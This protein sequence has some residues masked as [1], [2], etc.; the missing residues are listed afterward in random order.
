MAKLTVD[1]PVQVETIT[2]SNGKTAK[3][4]TGYNGI[5]FTSAVTITSPALAYR[6]QSWSGTLYWGKTSGAKTWKFAT[7][8]N[9]SVT[10][11]SHEQIECTGNRTIYITAEAGTAASYKVKVVL[12]DGISQVGFGVN[13]AS[14]SKLA[15]T[16]FTVDVG[17]GGYVGGYVPYGAISDANHALDSMYVDTLRI[18]G[19]SNYRIYAALS[20]NGI[21][22]G[23]KTISWSELVSGGGA[24]F[25]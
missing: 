22:A 1:F 25:G 2:F 14:V 18:M 6:Y 17:S 3:S 10:I 19:G 15:S 23:G 20:P 8:S 7:V 12:G 5:E 4:A 11:L 13:T 21:E 16:D 9:G 24:V